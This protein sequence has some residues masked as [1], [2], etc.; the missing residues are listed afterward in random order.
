MCL[1]YFPVI[2][3]ASTLFQVLNFIYFHLVKFYLLTFWEIMIYYRRSLENKT[4]EGRAWDE[5]RDSLIWRRYFWRCSLLCSFW[6]VAHAQSQVRR[7]NEAQW[8]RDISQQ[9]RKR[10]CGPNSDNST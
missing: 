5:R 9:R 7:N 2:R 6:E 1:P 10:P 3:L 8:A 4:K